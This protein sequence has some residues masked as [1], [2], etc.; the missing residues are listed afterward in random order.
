MDSTEVIYL[1]TA[2]GPMP[3][4]A[5]INGRLYAIDADHLNTPRRLTNTQGQVAWQWL[6]TGFGE[7]NPTTGATGYAQSGQGSSNYSEAIRLD[8][9]YPGQVFDEET[10]LNYNLNRSYDPPSGRYFQADPIGL[11]GGWNRFGYVGG[12]PLNRVDPTGLIDIGQMITQPNSSVGRPRFS[13]NP[14]DVRGGFDTDGRSLVFNP[15]HYDPNTASKILLLGAFTVA[16]GPSGSLC[17]P[18]REA[19][20]AEVFAARAAPEL[21]EILGWGNGLP[22]VQAA[23][24]GLNASTLARI[25]TS[26]SRAEIEALRDFYNAA[27]AAGRGGA[28]APARAAYMSE[29]LRHLK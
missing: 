18:A 2:N 19:L 27:S 6:I 22:G 25:Q 3:I 11:D 7:A 12:D 16:T 15:I 23:Q 26:M 10:Q 9:R 14:N 4:A 24:A 1:P 21:K 29:I 5:Q 20:K 8:L 13:Y 28:V 17:I